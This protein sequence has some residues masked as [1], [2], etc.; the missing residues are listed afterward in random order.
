MPLTKFFSA[1]Y[2]G[3]SPIHV[4]SF[5]STPS[6]VT[7]FVAFGKGGTTISDLA[8]LTSVM[9][10]SATPNDSI[11]RLEEIISLAHM[12]IMYVSVSK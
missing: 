6:S 10:S 5:F 12:V 2:P 11:V 9:F 4:S 8:N 7:S 3:K 1:Q